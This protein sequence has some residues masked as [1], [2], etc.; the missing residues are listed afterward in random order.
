MKQAVAAIIRQD[1]KILLCK[2]SLQAANQ[3]GKWENAGG[4]VEENETPEEAIV[5]EIKEELGVDFTIDKRVYED[6][7]ES[8]DDIY[9][10]II[11]SGSIVGVPKAMIEIETSEVKWFE[12]S[13]LENVDLATYTRKDFER[14]GW[15]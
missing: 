2:R 1:D 6:E 14:F 4:K 12:M 3:Q 15:V 8:E 13:E 11:F 7:F 5:R 10:V 9:Q